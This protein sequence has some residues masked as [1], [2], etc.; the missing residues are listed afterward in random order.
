MYKVTYILLF[1]FLIICY[2]KQI[3]SDENVKLGLSLSDI[4]EIKKGIIIIVGKIDVPISG[5]ET[6]LLKSYNNG[7]TWNRINIKILNN[8]L[9]IIYFIDKQIGFITGEWDV[10]GPCGPFILKT[11]DGGTTWNKIDIKGTKN[12]GGGQITNI[13]FMNKEDGEMKIYIYL[14]ELEETFFTK[15]CGNTWIFDKSE[16]I[17]NS[18]S[19]E[20]Q[21]EIR[22]VK[23]EE[24]L[25]KEIYKIMKYNEKEKKWIQIKTF[26]TSYKSYKEFAR[27]IKSN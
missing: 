11:I 15:D 13:H 3:Y 4:H 2:D 1:L 8:G 12:T 24:D 25:E 20:Y 23:I 16:S 6:L 22:N 17:N 18:E 26:K 27:L 10:E 21:K 7:K 14:D 5:H 9:E 19:Q